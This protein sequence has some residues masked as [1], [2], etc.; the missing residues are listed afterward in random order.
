MHVGL[1][2][3]HGAVIDLHL[4][5]LALDE[6]AFGHFDQFLN[7]CN[8]LLARTEAHAQIDRRRLADL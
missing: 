7:L 3:R 4:G 1:G 6:E 8:G 2:L 5:G